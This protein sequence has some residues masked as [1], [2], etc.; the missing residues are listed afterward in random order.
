M[1]HPMHRV[2]DSKVIGTLGC[3]RIARLMKAGP[4]NVG[5]K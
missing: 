4:S 1:N 5:V 3:R 2:V